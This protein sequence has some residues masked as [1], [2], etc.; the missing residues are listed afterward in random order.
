M[1]VSFFMFFFP[2]CVATETSFGQNSEVV[3]EFWPKQPFLRI[4]I[5]IL[6][7]SV[8]LPATPAAEA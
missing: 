4:K 1:V 2:D 3:S 7:V 5:C 6:S 8:S